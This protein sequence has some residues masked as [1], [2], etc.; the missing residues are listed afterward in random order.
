MPARLKLD[1]YVPAEQERIRAA[2]SFACRAHEGQKRRSGQPYISHPLAVAGYLI[3]LGMDAD[4]IMAGLLHDV[5]EDTPTE[6]SEIERL[7]G[8]DVAA[9]VDGV[10]KVGQVAYEPQPGVTERRQQVSAENI[11]K[12]LLAMSRDLRIIIIKLADRLHNLQTL[13]FL[14]EADRVR[15]G[16]ESLEVF[17]PLADRLGMGALK[18]EIE[19]LSFRYTNPTG[20][21][22]VKKLA[23]GRSA[24]SNAYL[25]RLKAAVEKMLGDAGIR[26]ESIHARRK[27]LYSIQRKLAKADGDISKI[28]DMIALR[29][30]VDDIPDCYKVLGVLH[31]NYKPLIY[32]IKDYIAVPKPNGYQSLHTTVFA[33]DGRIIEMQIR[34]PQMHREAEYGLAAHAL[35]NAFKDSKGYRK[36][37]V[38]ASDGKLS[39]IGELGSLSSQAEGGQLMED[40]K[41]DL[42]Q[43]RIFAFSP[44]GDLFDLPEGATPIDFAFAV[45]TN[46]GLRTQGARVNGKIAPLDRPLENRDVV[47]IITRKTPGPNRQWLSVVKTATARSRIRAWFRAAGREDNL[48]VGRTVLE[49]HLKAWGHKRLE[50]LDPEVVKQ[51]AAHFGVRDGEGILVGLG[52]G[53]LG[54]SQ[55]L[56]RLVPPVQAKPAAKVRPGT[57]EVA[58]PKVVGAPDL[59]CRVATCC[60]PAPPDHIIGYV[61]RGS[62][63]TVHRQGCTNMPAE[64]DRWLQCAWQTGSGALLVIVVE[65][66]ILADNRVGL[67]RDIT[68]IIAKSKIN[69]VKITTNDKDEENKRTHI[70]VRM[71]VVDLY[72]LSSVISQLEHLDGV[73][74]VIRTDQAQSAELPTEHKK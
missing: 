17:A 40:L 35:Y 2:E 51:A 68:D 1:R 33:L 58:V 37:R 10:T 59:E 16:R 31:Q 7:F 9:L 43:D 73:G 69:I 60:K 18:A 54:I 25:D 50:D 11:R 15:I 42:F 23:T 45:H 56:R 28:Y 3:E 67:V 8:A 57:V 52:E 27:H 21:A 53:T 29:I 47:E 65:L 34:T 13:E 71:E 41:L 63:I 14:P 22:L 64:P 5:V 19:D 24:E 48:A 6:L 32:R 49:S 38:M 66:E 74:E 20:Y 12:L 26:A 72:V 30:I 62:G 55:I 61:T 39:W 70:S 44:Q 46:V 36:G 4:T